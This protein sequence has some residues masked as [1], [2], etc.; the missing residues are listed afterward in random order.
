MGEKAVRLFYSYSHKDEM[1]RDA[2][3]THLSILKR[4]GLIE[5]WYDRNILPGENW[6]SEID[7]HINEADV[8]LLL[9]SP[10]FIASEYCYGKEL[11]KALERYESGQ[12]E[13][14][15][16][17]VRPVDWTDS[18][19]SKLQALPRDGRPITTWSNGDEAWLEA[20]KG[21]KKCIEN[22][23][24]KKAAS[25]RPHQENPVI[26]RSLVGDEFRRIESLFDGKRK[27]SGTSTGFNDLDRLVDGIHPG[28]I[29]LIAGRPSMGKSDFVINIA[30]QVSLE[31]SK[32]VVYFS[33]RKELD[34]IQRRF[35]AS[36]SNVPLSRIIR[37][38]IKESDWANLAR[39]AG[40]LAEM[41]IY[42]DGS[43]KQTDDEIAARVK[44]HKE[45]HELGLVVIDGIEHVNSA[46]KQSIQSLERGLIIAAIQGIARDERIPVLLTANTSRDHELRGDKRPVIRDLDEW[47]ML[48]SDAAHIV[49]FL[50]RDEVYNVDSPHKGTTEVIVAKNDYG[51]AAT[52]RLAY[53][54]E[55]CLFE[56]AAGTDT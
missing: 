7:N 33:M 53:F 28:D 5:D 11:S 22:V 8:I 39:A 26:L 41:P 36:E 42:I 29:L 54:P 56:N 40:L 9:V 48:A 12:A 14:V 15:P 17:I 37:G 19:F 10:D 32:S 51:P 3:E 25:L 21:I 16:I 30:K 43:P 35:L 55:Y 18:P 47:E 23:I 31:S 1:F 49:I 24:H 27:F 6:K 50:Y 2:L 13:V 46:K 4:Q 44:K 34:Q 45:I 20:E 38:D 52:I